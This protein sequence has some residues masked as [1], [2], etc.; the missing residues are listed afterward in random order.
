MSTAPPGLASVRLSFILLV[1]AVPAT[2]DLVLGPEVIV[3][4]GGAA[5]D[6]PGYSVPSFVAWDG[7]AHRAE[8]LKR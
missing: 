4:A 7:D 5:I 2:A 8:R 1:C 3:Q 6:V